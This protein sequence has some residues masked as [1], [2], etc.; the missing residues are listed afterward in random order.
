MTYKEFFNGLRKVKGK[1]KLKEGYEVRC[2]QHCPITFYAAKIAKSG[3]YETGNYED[4]ALS[5]GL[6][7]KRAQKIVDAADD[8]ACSKQERSLRKQLLQTLKLKEKER[9]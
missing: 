1:W 5:I 2:G 6:S 8:L 3:Q 7:L 9:E 4:A